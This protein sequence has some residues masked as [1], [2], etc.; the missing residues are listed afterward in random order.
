M[1]SP[2]QKPLSLKRVLC[3]TRSRRKLVSELVGGFSSVETNRQLD[4][5]QFG[6]WK[7]NEKTVNVTGESF[8]AGSKSAERKTHILTLTKIGKFLW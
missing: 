8:Y 5:K 3:V 4:T 1:R 6:E 7:T 2:S